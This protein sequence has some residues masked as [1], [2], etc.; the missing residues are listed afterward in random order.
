MRS[1]LYVLRGHEPV[2]V[3]HAKDWAMMFEGDI[4]RRRVAET[5]VGDFW[6]STVFLGVDHN[7]CEAGPPLLF[8]TMVFRV[9]DGTPRTSS[10]WRYS[11]WEQAE[12]GHA[13]AVALVTREAPS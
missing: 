8:E 7:F 13:A 12:A 1:G 3:E 5:E 10:S 2:E 6:V 11:T 4:D 9:S